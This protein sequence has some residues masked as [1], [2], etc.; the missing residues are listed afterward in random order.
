MLKINFNS[1]LLDMKLVASLASIKTADDLALGMAGKHLADEMQ[2]TIYDETENWP[3][4]SPITIKIKGNDA[5]LLDTNEMVKSIEWRKDG[6]SVTIGIHDDAPNDRAMIAL[7]HEH[8]NEHVPSRPFIMPTWDR[9]KNYVK[10]L[11][12]VALKSAVSSKIL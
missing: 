11:F 4:L 6:N 12:G 1:V 10:V 9:E 7:V 8:G 5:K 3:A 2:K